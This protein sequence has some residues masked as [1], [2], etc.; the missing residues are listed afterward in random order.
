VHL[1]ETIGTA[2]FRDDEGRRI[3][4]VERHI[5]DAHCGIYHFLV[6]GSSQC[7]RSAA[8]LDQNKSGSAWLGLKAAHAVHQQRQVPFVGSPWKTDDDPASGQ[9]V[10]AGPEAFAERMIR[11]CY[12]SPRMVTV[13]Q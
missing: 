12:D 2:G 10:E 6:D 7:R 3:G 8:V 11:E 9:S 13:V 4:P 5:N 1:T